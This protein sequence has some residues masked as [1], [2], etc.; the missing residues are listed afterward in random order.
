MTEE[1]TFSTGAVNC[2]I[3]TDDRPIEDNGVR[4]FPGKGAYNAIQVSKTRTT[5]YMTGGNSY[6]KQDNTF[7]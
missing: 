3:V 1:K 5:A 4:A 6:A 2:F 7:G